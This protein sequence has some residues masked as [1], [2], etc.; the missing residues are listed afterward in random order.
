MHF[1]PDIPPTTSNVRL[2]KVFS[3][4][5]KNDTVMTQTPA[6][7]VYDDQTLYFDGSIATCSCSQWRSQKVCLGASP[8]PFPSPFTSPPPL[9]PIPSPHLPTLSS[10]P[11]RSMALILRLRGLE[12][13]SQRPPNAFWC[14][15]NVRQSYCARYSY[16]L[17]VR[18]SVRHTLVLCRN[19]STY[20]QSVF[21]AW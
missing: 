21:T 16:S 5:N 8:L 1:S 9:P 3:Q 7:V 10:S 15:F 4:Y 19:G 20:R 17:S 11:L 13:F 2:A 6:A 14:I 18:P 12:E